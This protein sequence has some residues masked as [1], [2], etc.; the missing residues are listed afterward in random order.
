MRIQLHTSKQVRKNHNHAA[1]R[2]TRFLAK[3][4]KLRMHKKRVPKRLWDFGLVVESEILTRMARGQDRRTGYEE[5]T[6]Q[7]AYISE[8]I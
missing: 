2:E 6:D 1:K 8:W 3:Q 7:T 4:R 5:V